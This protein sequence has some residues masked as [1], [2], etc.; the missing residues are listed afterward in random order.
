M[1]KNIVVVGSGYVG[2]SLALL[3]SQKKNVTI[4]DT[5]KNKLASIE[6]RKSP[7]EDNL[8]E[9]IIKKPNLRLTTCDDLLQSISQKNNNIHLVI[10]ALPT[11]YDSKTN[12]FD[13]SIV[14]KVISE[15]VNINNESTIVIKSTVPLGFTEKMRGIY[16]KKN[17]IFSPEF[18]REGKALYDNLYPSRIVIG[19]K[20]IKGRQF[21]KLLTNSTYI[22][23]KKINIHL[24]ESMEAEAVKLFSNTYLA[25]RVAFFNELDTFSE[26][27]KVSSK[28][29]ISAVSDDPRIGNYYNNPSFG[30]GGYCLPKDTKQLLRTYKK[31]PNKL[32]KA[33][34]DSNKTRKLF[35]SNSIK[36]KYPKRIGVFRLA[37]KSGS[38]NFRDSAVLDL[39]KILKKQNLQIYLYEPLL[40]KS[41]IKNV[42]LINNFEQFI[43]VSDLIIANR[44]SNK[45]IK[46]K[47]KV[48]TRDLFGEN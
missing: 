37:M 45:L 18:L 26:V 41:N 31:I 6:K 8:A 2:T 38:D 39:I 11:N 46:V 35:I 27:N 10:I 28:D 7:I 47:N 32:I 19:D 36:K 1:I 22:S 25:M 5:D 48:Y 13:T 29:I 33:V 30:Y 42:L 23:K 17:I 43:S 9:K 24:M 14:E 16:S 15:I 21:A 4:V 40:K 20:T 12:Y 3:L 34:I 44:M